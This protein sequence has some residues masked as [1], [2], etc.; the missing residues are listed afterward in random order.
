M[1]ANSETESAAA[2]VEA[3]D[4]SVV[5]RAVPLGSSAPS[6]TEVNEPAARASAPLSDETP[7]DPPPVPEMYYF[8]RLHEQNRMQQSRRQERTRNYLHMALH[9][10][11][12][13]FLLPILGMIYWPYLLLYIAVIIVFL[14]W[15]CCCRREASTGLKPD[16]IHE[17][18]IKRQCQAIDGNSDRQATEHSNVLEHQTSDQSVYWSAEPHFDTEQVVSYLFSKPLTMDDMKQITNANVN[19]DQAHATETEESDSKKTGKPTECCSL[20]VPDLSSEQ[21]GAESEDDDDNRAAQPI[22]GAPTTMSDPLPAMGDIESSMDNLQS[23]DNDPG[24]AFDERSTSHGLVCDICLDDYQ[25]NQ[26]V[27]WSKNVECKHAFHVDC[28]SDWLQR[29]PTCPTCR[30]EYITVGKRT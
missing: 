3:C 1:T 16:Q 10:A 20:D 4:P 8:W 22:N 27:A 6:P 7:V 15:Y 9:C 30:Q 19:E 12:L 21:T 13:M 29:R 23:T 17:R 24:D 28:I 11:L 2:I 18:L 26:V 5:T 14:C 25:V